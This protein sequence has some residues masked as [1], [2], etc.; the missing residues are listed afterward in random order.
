MNMRNP[1]DFEKPSHQ[2]T[3]VLFD[4]KFKDVFTTNMK[5]DGTISSLQEA[6]HYKAIV[7]G[8]NGQILSIVG[9][10]YQLISNKEALELGKDIFTQLYPNIKRDDLIPYKVVAPQTKTSAHI[11]LIHK[12][13]NFNVW[14]QETWLPFLR[15]TNSYNRT[16]AL[17]FEVG[18]VRKLCSNGVLFDKKTMKIKYYH[19][20]ENKIRLE[21]D[22]S[23]IMAAS[24]TFSKQCQQLKDFY[25]PK[26]L[27]IPFVFKAFNINLETKDQKQSR[28]KAEKLSK[29][30][31]TTI[32][33]VDFYAN[34]MGEN[35]Y[36]ALNI[37]TDIVSHQDV[38]KCLPGY[39][40]SIRSYYTRP[41]QWMDEFSIEIAN[42][43]FDLSTYLSE[44]VDK[45]K[46]FSD[47]AGLN[48]N[49]N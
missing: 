12:D 20:R 46:V 19:T 6:Y 8:S 5:P 2:L 11:D 36:S 21:S 44:E 18:F 26:K 4:V 47:V 24:G 33:T 17:S 22:V 28:Q 30:M 32:G 9:N 34:S 35:A 31:E 42:Q 16:Y 25:F 37:L 29:L 7:N 1:V 40:L 23:H 49:L 39:Y 45:L 38:N 3:D 41:T 43:E 48:W 27:M 15:T 13:V 14:D 10:N